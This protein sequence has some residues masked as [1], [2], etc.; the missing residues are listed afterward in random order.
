MSFLK[1]KIFNKT[2]VLQ[3]L[4]TIYGIGNVSATN[5]CK[6]IGCNP[7]L[8]FINLRE[9]QIY[10]ILTYIEKHYFLIENN[11]KLFQKNNFSYLT[12][13]KNYR[14][15][16]HKAGLPARGQRTHTNAN[17]KKKFKKF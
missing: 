16:R 2:T 4:T 7:S 10:K 9:D 15:L 13:V 11:L 1:K 14:S 12:K 17:T 5:I 3:N 8:S 6:N